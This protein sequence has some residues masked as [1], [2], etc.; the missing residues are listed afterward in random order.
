MSAIAE[1]H[2]THSSPYDLFAPGAFSRMDETDDKSFYARDRFVQ[3][4]DR[5]ALSTVE[6][7]VG[8]LINEEKPVILDLMAGW[9]SHIPN[10]LS[11]SR[12]VGLGLNRNELT[13][14]KALSDF[15]IH[16]LNEETALPFPDNTFDAVI[17]TVSVDYMTRP[18]EVFSEVKRI[19]KPGGLFLVIFSN[20]M[21]PQKATRVW[22]ESS[23]Q[24]RVVMVE[25]FF[26]LTEGFEKPRTFVSKGRPRPKDDKYAHLGIPSDPVYAVYADKKGAPAHKKPRPE[27]RVYSEHEWSDEELKQRMQN[28]KHTLLCPYCG[29]KMKKW[30]VPVS[31]FST[32][33]IEF[34]YICFNDECGYLLRGW[35]SM[36]RQGNR[37]YSYRVMYDPA[38]NCCMPLPVPTLHAL[39]EGIVEDE[40]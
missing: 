39:K 12:V 29:E 35:E 4:L 13:Q 37:G 8:E 14:N 20:R 15:V 7:L 16:D 21:F 38:R 18:F 24:E 2:A 34:A 31:P 40:E 25:Q 11:P 10:T 27:V 9:D 30:R 26:N 33:D 17:N 5:L 22:Q 28:V 23:E 32:W 6:K 3:H 1:K 36:S 19:L